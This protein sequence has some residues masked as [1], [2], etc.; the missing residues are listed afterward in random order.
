MNFAALILAG[1]SSRRMGQDK[2]LL[3]LNGEPLLIRTSRIAAAVCDS[4]WIC[5]PEPDRYQSLLSQPV[6]WLTE[7]QPTGPQG[8]L[9]ALAW[10]LPQIDADWILLLA[11]DL[12]RLAIAPLQAWRQQVELLPEDCRAAIARTEQGWEPLI[13]FYRP[14][15]APTIA[16]WLSQGR[17][18]FQGWL[19]TVAVQELP[20][21][22]RDWLVNCNTPTDWQA[23]QLS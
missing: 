10:A 15:I 14:A 2:A 21:S 4:V 17:R 19:A 7:P 12:P 16:P 1:G 5:S 23:L 22:D 18:D 8:P 20:L 9:T 6:Q 13:G 3:R 11:C